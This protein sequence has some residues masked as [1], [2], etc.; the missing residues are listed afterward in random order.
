[1][2]PRVSVVVPAYDE[3]VFL[4]DAL[5]SVGAQTWTDFECIVVDDGSPRDL[6][7]AAEAAGLGDRLRFVRQPN[8]GGGA[9]RN[10]GIALARGDWIAFLDHDDRW[11]PQKLEL[12][13]AAVDRHPG[14]GLAFCRYTRT[15]SA[16]GSEAFPAEAPS[17][18][19]LD[20]LL[21]RTLIR[22]LSTVLVRRDVVPPGE[23]F[24]T[25]LAVAND[26]ELYYRIAERS[27]LVFVPETLV[28]WRRHERSASVDAL[29]LHREATRVVEELAVRLGPDAPPPLRKL[30]RA[31]LGR[32]V[33]GAASAALRSGDR[34][35]ARREYRRALR[36]QADPL[37]A[38][39]GFLATLVPRR[40]S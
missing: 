2:T 39:F 1:M 37:R 5:R 3:P 21:R 6:R 16:A 7:P 30:L 10:H 9:A 40:P 11:L 13:L 14:A 34:R 29:R 12:Q 35:A 17:G 20:A 4:T 15:G 38:A 32:H 26:V 18:R 8:A 24:R 36:L 25:D 23:W 22:T 19:I 31:R 33:L 27:D 28:E